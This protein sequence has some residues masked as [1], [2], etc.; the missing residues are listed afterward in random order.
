MWHR[1]Q[2]KIC[3]AYKSLKQALSHGLLFK[4]MHRVIQ[5]NQKDWLKPYVDM[6]TKEEKKQKMILKKLFSS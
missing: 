6:N 3:H 1:R 4:K 2:R 5:F